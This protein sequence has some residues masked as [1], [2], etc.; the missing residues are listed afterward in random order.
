MPEIRIRF[1]RPGKGTTEW[2]QELVTE[3]SDFI[4]S[5]FRFDVDRPLVVD[6]RMVIASGHS[7]YLFEMV[8]ENTEIVA[9]F[10]PLGRPTGY[11]VNLNSEPRRFEGGYEVTDWFLDVWVFP[12]LRYRVLDEDEFGTAVERG[13]IDPGTAARAREALRRVERA[14]AARDFP[15]LAVREFFLRPDA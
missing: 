15:P 5:S 6:G 2:A 10:D 1:L 7:G 9:V 4:L 12:D 14:I 8:R 13:V 11:Y 3:T